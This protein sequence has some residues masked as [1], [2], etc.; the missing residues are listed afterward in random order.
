MSL[1]DIYNRNQAGALYTPINDNVFDFSYGGGGGGNTPPTVSTTPTFDVKL[2]LRNATAVPNV[3]TFDVQNRTYNENATVELNSNTLNDVLRINPTAR[4]NFEPTNRFEIVKKLIEKQILVKDVIDYQPYAFNLDPASSLFGGMGG[5]TGF[6]GLGFINTPIPSRPDLNKFTEISQTIKVNGVAVN[7]YDNNNLL[8]TS[9]DYPLA[10]NIVLDFKGTN[11]TT[12]TKVTQTY[13]R[14]QSIQFTSNYTNDALYNEIEIEID[15]IDLKA[16]KIVNKLNTNG[17]ELL[18]TNTIGKLNPVNISFKGFSAFTFRNLYW[19]YIDKIDTNTLNL[20]EFN[21]V[22]DTT[23]KLSSD[24]FN[25]N[26]VVYLDVIPANSKLPNLTLKNNKIEQ[27]ILESVYVSKT[28]SALIDI[29]LTISNTDYV[30]I[31]TPY[32]EFN[33]QL[34]ATTATTSRITLDLKRDFL[35][36][37]GSFKVLLVPASNLYGEGSVSDVIVKLTKT[38]DTP[39]IDKVDYPTNVYIPS[40]T[41]GDVKFKVDFESNLADY[42]LVYHSTENDNNILG[43]FGAKGSLILNYNELKSKQVKFPLDLL[44]VPY[45]DGTKVVRGET[46]RLQITFS[47]AGI[48]VSTQDLKN[49]L[50]D[51]ISKNLNLTLQTEEKYLSH[52]A[53]FDKN[54]SQILISNW[55]SDLTTFTKFKRDELGNQVPDGQINKSVVLKLYEAL[56]ANITKN[57]VLWVS[58]LSSLPIIQKVIINSNPEDNTL[59]LRAPNFNIQADYVKGQSTIYESYNDLI[60]SGSS[61]SQQLVDKYLTDNLVETA[62]INIDYSEFSNFV[63]YSSAKERLTNFRYKKELAEYYE[64]KITFLSASYYVSRSV[65]TLND[66][67]NYTDTLSTLVSGF[68]GWEKS[69]VS[70]SLIFNSDTASY[71]SFPGG[72]FNELSGTDAFS[73]DGTDYLTDVNSTL[74]NWFLGTYESASVFDDN[75]L[76]SLRNN[77]PLFINDNPENDEFLL[78]LDM[79]GNHFDIIHTYIKGMTEQRLISENN[80]Y[81]INDELLYNYLQSL[82][83]DAKNLNSNKQLWSYT[84]GQDAD[85]DGIMD[86]VD[87]YTITPEEYTKKIWRR[88]SNNL[89]YLL[90]HKGTGRGIKALMACYGVPQSALTIMEFGGPADNRLA[91][92]SLFTYETLSPT[93]VFNDNSYITASWSGSTK[94]QSIELVIKPEYSSSINLVSGSGF[95]LYISGGVTVNDTINTQYGTLGLNVAGVNL[96]NTLPYTFFDGNFH[97][98]LLTKEYDGSNSD[99][100]IYYGYA[101]KDRIVKKRIDYT[102]A[103][104]NVWEGGSHIYIG[105]FRGELDEVKIW[106]SALSASLFDIHLLDSEN[107]IGNYIS[108]STEDLLIRLDF[109]NPHQLSGSVIEIQSGSVKDYIKNVAPNVILSNIT[110]SVKYGERLLESGYVSYVSASGFISASQYDSTTHQHWNYLYRSKDS[111]V[112]LPNT[113]VTRLSNNKIRIEG[114]ELIGDLSPTKRVTKKAFDTAANDSNRLGLFFSPNKDLDLDI[115]KSFGG[116]AIDDY[117]GDP[118]DDYNNTYKD[119]DDLRNYYFQRVSNRNI[120]D[121]IR[122]I[123]YYDKSLFVNIKQMLPARVKATTGLLIAPH[124]LERSKVK[125][126]KP[127]AENTQLEGVISDTT[128][129]TLHSTFD[130]YEGNLNLSESIDVLSGEYNTYEANIST[131]EVTTIAGEYNTYDATIGDIVEDLVSATYDTYEGTIDFKLKDPTILAQ[132][133]LFGGATIVGLDDKYSEYGFNTYFN[134]G[135][136]KY[137]YEENGSFKSKGIRAFMVTKKDTIIIPS[138][139]V[140][141]IYTNVL[142]SSYHNELIIQDIGVSASLAS[143]PNIIGITTASGYLPSHYIYKS[144]KSIGLQNLFYKGSKQT[145]NTTIDGKD[146][147]ETFI[148]NPTVLRINKQGRNTSEPILEV[149]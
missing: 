147:V 128:I 58:R 107:M 65:I 18:L 113:G 64:D 68:D 73:I 41:F 29:D 47:D 118:A 88:I 100:T 98:I 13:T 119:L 4:D 97:T 131:E 134:N 103:A 99:F 27:S 87:G 20:A 62:K 57:D 38:L 53:S 149:D 81:G 141:G 94:P 70:S 32:R 76:S 71:G 145:T 51:A 28:E 110:S 78:F 72:R 25:R 125:H 130:T 89:P 137:H 5:N 1:A 133:D 84:F 132:Y 142:T 55:D 91:S 111:A 26:I 114:Q 49:N 123:K 31:K 139:S 46:E 6:S 120:Y 12:V 59:P 144:G 143:D 11:K 24:E 135:Y 42:I 14:T 79:I 105:G 23:L 116:D 16:G 95:K 63:K 7:E 121:F 148:T 10:A 115:A 45:N 48:Y 34:V 40:Y 127:T 17:G 117:F 56:P 104:N 44:L 39:I 126:T 3:F 93:L 75:N 129:T 122:L 92:A 19:Q 50:F 37:E 2:T 102:T 83:W 9:T 109:E 67:Q 140:G 96:F 138:A 36:N 86:E 8:L 106:K 101:E 22:N 66:I 54:D 136:G 112:E 61:T 60:L 146:A 43:K 77:I 108:A 35:N 15:T 69:L 124:F 33:Q 52:I 21:S 90:K 74:H 82:S 80:S 85:G 30:R